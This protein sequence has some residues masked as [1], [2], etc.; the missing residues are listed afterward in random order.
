MKAL[1]NTVSW[2]GGALLSLIVAAACVQRGGAPE[3]GSAVSAPAGEAAAD[4]SVP[5]GG[6]SL[7]GGEGITAFQPSGAT[8]KV[9]LRTIEVSGQPFDKAVEAVV[10]EAGQSE[11]EVQLS[12]PTKAAVQKDD[13][14]LATFYVRVEKE[15]ETGGGQTEFVFELGA[16]P[17]TK[18]VS[19]PV[20]LTTD[21]RKVNVRFRAAADYAPGQANLHFRLG[22]TPETIQI[23]GLT[24]EN[25]AKTVLLSNLPTTQAV[26]RKL[27][28]R[29]A[30]AAP[31]LEPV[32][33]GELAFQIQPGK[34][35]RKIS[36]YVYGINSQPFDDTGATVRRNGGNRGSA[37]NWETNDSNA[38][39]DYIHNSDQWPCTILNIPNCDQP[40]AQFLGFFE[41]NKQAGADTIATVPMLDY[42]TA[43]KNGPVKPEEKA[44]S[45]RWVP[46]K[47]RKGQPFADPPDLND[48]VVYQDE[49][50]AYLVKKLGKADKGG[51]KFYS[52]D[53]EPALWP[54]THPLVHPEHTSYEEMVR[55]TEETAAAIKEVDKSA[56]LLGAVMFGW[57]EFQS[58]S[59]APDSAKYNAAFGT[60]TDFFLDAMKRLEKKHGR[61]LVDALDIHWYP[62]ARGTQ[63]IT[64]DESSRATLDER[65]QAPRSLWDPQYK[66][67][68]WIVQQTGK[69]IRLIPWLR[70]L[71]QKRYPGTELTMT[72]YNYG[73]TADV[74]GGLAQVDV[75]G[76]LG[77]EGVYLATYWGKGAAVEP[78]PPYVAAAFKLYRNY[79]GKG[80]K[81]GDTAVE[82]SVPN[83]DA[84]S[85]FAATDASGDLTVIAIN[86]HQQNRYTGV[87]DLG[88]GKP[89]KAVKTFVIDR[90][91]TQV[92]PGKPAELKGN[93]LRY[94]LEPL[95][96]TLIVFQKS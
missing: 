3:A 39:K 35:L 5:S 55:R 1:R 20:P 8:S 21:W 57:S 40:A 27:A 68:S 26:D 79:D 66:E 31:R 90:S 33:A 32:D 81:F 44:P 9:E 23:G 18:S 71:I 65:L 74:S 53:N 75:L 16:E 95:S 13:V 54:E 93:T 67:K 12:A 22:Y 69:P 72:E 51:I 34:V 64:G 4:S 83:A 94:T 63:R 60:Y 49:F 10:K 85:V 24:V 59:S 84:A 46:S 61:R 45:K 77:R 30:V 29:P 87:F 14:L 48:G 88:K 41:K 86:K 92:N 6:V 2:G 56:F 73:G 52:L 19:Y 37:Y 25:F 70:E 82:A 50:V 7:L 42:V 17:Y 15:Q 62:E 28:A 78:L 38:G 36:R 47:P 96:A 89:Y 11:W 58:L 91:N 43:D 80:G 76:V